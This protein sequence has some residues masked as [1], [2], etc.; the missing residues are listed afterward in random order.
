M[1]TGDAD[2]AAAIAVQNENFVTSFSRDGQVSYHSVDEAMA[3]YRTMSYLFPVI[4]FLVAAAIAFISISKMVESQRSQIAVMQAMGVSKMKIR[5]GFLSY[6]L[7][8]SVLG[9][10]PFAVLGNLFV[11]SYITGIFTMQYD[12]PGVINRL[13]PAY[14]L[15]PLLL[16][17][18]FTGAA[19][20]LAVQRALRETPSQ[21]MRPRAPKHTRAILLERWGAFWR[22]TKHATRLALR[23]VFGH[24]GRILLSSVGVIGSVMLLV[25]GFSLRDSAGSIIQTTVESMPYDLAVMLNEAPDNL[26][27]TPGAAYA[28]ALEFTDSTAGSLLLDEEIA[29]RFQFVSPGSTLVHLVG[30]DGCAIAFD[31]NTVVLPQTVAAA[32]GIHP[33][34]T[35]ETEVRGTQA[36][37]TVTDIGEEYLAKTLYVSSPAAE[38]AGM[39]VN[40]DT[41]LMLLRDGS[42][43]AAVQDMLRSDPSVLGVTSSAD[44]VQK[45]GDAVL[46]LN[47]VIVVIILAAAVLAVAVLYNISAVNILERTREYATLLVLG[48]SRKD[49]NRIIS[50]ENTALTAV[51]CLL[52]IP[53]GLGLFSYMAAAISRDDLTLPNGF[54]P[55]A[56]MLSILFVFLFS[57]LTSRLLRGKIRRIHL[58]EEIKGVE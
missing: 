27:Q 58:V 50:A 13:M 57:I 48:Y 1:V 37:F 5:F 42:D 19:A 10:L 15:L 9:A 4:F 40:R 36:A 16:S 6:A 55:L 23:N 52:G 49:V 11:P 45:A 44:I 31:E 18:A 38:A 54:G 29:M 32:Y 7:T 2:T 14:I 39:E 51:G 34:D 3:P 25:A 41:V 56:V 12:L 46:M 28:E 24:K 17:F 21:G 20:L 26:Q 35:I 30:A 22:R 33:G 8:A 47:A 43:A 53:A